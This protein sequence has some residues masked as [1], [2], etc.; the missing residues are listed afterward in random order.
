MAHTSTNE[1]KIKGYLEAKLRDDGIV[2]MKWDPSLEI[3]EIEH[4]KKLQEAL[5]EL[6]D[7]KKVPFVTMPHDFLTLSK[8]GSKYA[9]SD[10]GVRYSLAIAVIIDNLAKKILLNFFLN[11]NKAKVP[12]KGFTKKEDAILWLKKF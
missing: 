4:L 3:I 7:G 6:G 2:E 8:E 9:T 5:C 12:T 10:E 11:F 1:I